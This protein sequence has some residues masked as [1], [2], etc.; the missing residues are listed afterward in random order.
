MCLCSNSGL[1]THNRRHMY[2]KEP[3]VHSNVVPQITIAGRTRYHKVDNSQLWALSISK[4]VTEIFVSH[5]GRST[6]LI[7][8]IPTLSYQSSPCQQFILRYRP[9]ASLQRN[10]ILWALYSRFHID[11]PRRFISSSAGFREIPSASLP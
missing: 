1:I 2:K 8:S 5:S 4:D 3:A 11:R 6:A 7:F 10:P 9:S